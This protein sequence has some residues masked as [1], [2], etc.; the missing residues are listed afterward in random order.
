[1]IFSRIVG[2]GEL[3]IHAIMSQVNTPKPNRHPI[4]RIAET[5]YDL[6]LTRAGLDHVAGRVRWC[7][8]PAYRCE[9]GAELIELFFEV[10]SQRSLLLLG[11][12]EL[13]PQSL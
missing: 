6:G 8:F 2:A 13:I 10:F 1:M 7:F 3:A 11:C 9:A 12:L 4:G 5:P